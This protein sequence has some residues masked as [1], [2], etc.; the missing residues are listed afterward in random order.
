VRLVA[1]LDHLPHRGDARRTQQLFELGEM[2][3]FARG[4]RGNHERALTGPATLA[5]GLLARRAI[6]VIGGSALAQL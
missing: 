5:L 2:I 1:T 3:L 4:D 6:S